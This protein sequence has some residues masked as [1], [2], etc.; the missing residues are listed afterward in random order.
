MPWVDVENNGDGD[1]FFDAIADGRARFGRIESGR[2]VR[3]MI[4]AHICLMVFGT[5]WVA[6]VELG[7]LHL[8]GKG[9]ALVPLRTDNAQSFV[10]LHLLEQRE[11]GGR[12]GLDVPLWWFCMWLGFSRGEIDA[13][14]AAD[15]GKGRPSAF[16]YTIWGEVTLLLEIATVIWGHDI[17]V[18]Q[19]DDPDPGPPAFGDQRLHIRHTGVPPHFV[20]MQ[21]EAP[22]LG[23]LLPIGV[24]PAK[25]EP[26][27]A[28]AERLKRKRT[29]SEALETDTLIVDGS[30]EPVGFIYPCGLVKGGGGK[31][32]AIEAP[33][34]PSSKRAK[35]A[36][37]PEPEDDG[38][39]PQPDDEVEIHFLDVGMGDCTLLLSPCGYTVLVDLGSVNRSINKVAYEDALRFLHNELLRQAER[40]GT[41]PTIDRLYFTHPDPDHKNRFAAL[42][43]AI[44]ASTG[45]ELQVGD[46]YLGGSKKD[47]GIGNFKGLGNPAKMSAT[48]RL[49]RC[50][51]QLDAAGKV[52]VLG[53]DHHE[54][55]PTFVAL[56]DKAAYLGLMVMSANATPLGPPDRAL[57]PGL[58]QGSQSNRNSIV[59]GVKVR[60]ESGASVFG[61]LMADAEF[62]VEH[63]IV[64]SHYAGLLASD[65]NAL[66]CDFLKLGHHGTRNASSEMFL[67]TIRPARVFVSSDM[68]WGHPYPEAVSR[69]IEFGALLQ[70]R[71]HALI[72]S[73]PFVSKKEGVE[74]REYDVDLAIFSNMARMVAAPVQSAV[75]LAEIE[76]TG[77]HRVVRINVDTAFIGVASRSGDDFIMG[78]WHQ[79]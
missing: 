59:L 54:P 75:G 53:K 21:W 38:N 55:E 32:G 29:S 65:P 23:G 13:M 15:K 20:A 60:C 52:H 10:N 39:A 79:V 63:H 43:N 19:A 5:D 47:Y 62:E 2:M 7:A 78:F 76:V 8:A 16:P 27:P 44:F 67:R 17:L 41:P 71:P 14:R 49:A 58:T 30:N 25:Q 1:C 3:Q 73:R 18:H 22:L 33:E 40:R 74:Y 77:A 24:P 48:K 46:V 57:Y 6:H 66:H 36:P 56:G 70:E 61:M 45:G 34:A 9:P 51:S 26:E 72:A 12:N 4:A 42:L 64:K 68:T 31:A 35:S 37:N 50:L 11:P 69:A 28:E